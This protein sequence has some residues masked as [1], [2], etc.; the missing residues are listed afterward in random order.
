MKTAVIWNE[1]EQIKYFV[2]DGDFRKYQGVYV[3]MIEPEGF[4]PKGKFED[5][6]DQMIID[7]EDNEF[8]SIEEFSKAIRDG[9]YVIE[10][11]FFP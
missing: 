8:R 1:I 5:I 7:F 3:N 11:G 6:A 2:V 4:L 10:C 9:A